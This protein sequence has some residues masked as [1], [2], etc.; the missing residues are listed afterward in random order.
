[1]R[2]GS[3][4]RA[5]L[6]F[7]TL[8]A[9]IVLVHGVI[10]TGVLQSDRWTEVGAIRFARYTRYF[11]LAYLILAIA[12]RRYLAISITLPVVVMTVLGA[13]LIP[14]FS[15][16]LLWVSCAALGRWLFRVQ[17]WALAFLGGLCVWALGIAFLAHVELHYPAVYLAIHVITLLLRRRDAVQLLHDA[18]EAFRPMAAPRWSTLLGFGGFLYAFLAQW[19]LVWK[20][21]TSGD[22]VAMHL[23]IALDFANNHVYTFDYHQ[24]IW[25][26]MPMGADFC[27]AAVAV[28]GGEYAARLLNLV[29][30]ATVAYLI[31][32]CCHRWL[33]SGFA[34]LLAALF[35]SAPI[36]QLVTGSMFVE[37]FTAALAAGSML[38]MW[39][40]YR[41]RTTHTLYL[42]AFL[43]GS[44]VGWKLG[45]L[46]IAVGLLPFLVAMLRTT[47]RTRAAAIA[48]VLF[49]LP[50]LQPYVKAYVLTGTPIFPFPSRWFSSPLIQE[51]LIDYRFQQP[52]T[53]HT[54]YD[55]TF[56]TQRY[57][58]GQ[59]GSFAYHYLLLI[60]ISLIAIW[61]LREFE[62]RSAIVA[63]LVAVTA[64]LVG[65]PNARYLYPALPLVMVGGA[66]AIGLIARCD[67]RLLHTSIAALIGAGAL[68]IWLLPTSN[69]FHRDFYLSPLFHERGRVDYVR[70]ILPVREVVPY[71]NRTT[72]GVLFV[73]NPD[74]AGVRPPV[75][76]N[77]WHNLAFRQRIERARNP[78]HLLAIVR[79]AGIE[80]YVKQKNVTAED[81]EKSPVLFKFLDLCAQTEFETAAYVVL[82]TVS[83]CEARITA[84]GPKFETLVLPPGKYNDDDMRLSYLGAWDPGRGF[85]HAFER[86][87]SFTHEN[88]AE[89]R[90]EFSGSALIYGFTRAFNRGRAQIYLDGKLVEVLDQYSPDIQ[91]QSQKRYVVEAPGRH[92]VAIRVTG[93]KDVNSKA[94][95]VDLDYLVVEP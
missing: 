77:N 50:A 70:A 63:G 28:L 3:V 37:N 32:R 33:S 53:W 85:E 10:S 39:R 87:V 65:Q 51:S 61:K 16:V 5:L 40:F 7:V 41:D 35:V 69:W 93:E 88:G 26:V 76:T 1:M 74:I 24:F 92:S 42:C 94:A 30:F 83:N 27:Y 91:W 21:E 72:G 73:Q 14:F 17:D 8:G 67:R 20:P 12:L 29:M 11:A 34:Y 9:V 31:F 79:R 75:F 25:A 90:F 38:A 19:I 22:A 89:I 80:H 56:F 44:G 55:L 68:N 84:A 23:A 58:E 45:G 54:L 95:F 81:L 64:V 2:P 4:Y 78:K 47:W 59:S 86:T 66:A 48:A 57:Y 15:V 6:W 71:L 52:F 43:L 18:R 13:G 60:P 82:R 49:L 36:A 62:E 46:A